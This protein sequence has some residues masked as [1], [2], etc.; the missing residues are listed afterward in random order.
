ML[1]GFRF[2]F[3]AIILSMSILVF[4]LGAAAL[5]RAAHEQFASTPAWRAGPETN[6]AQQT[7]VPRDAARDATR[8]VLA[9]LRVEPE[10]RSSDRIPAVNI[11]VSAEPAAMASPPAEPEQI[12]ASELLQPETT[13]PAVARPDPAAESPQQTE[14]AAAPTDAVTDTAEAAPPAAETKVAS[15]EQS[16]S[17]QILS[18]Q[19][20]SPQVLSP[21]NDVAPVISESAASEPVSAPAA[22]ATDPASTRIATLGGPA[23]AIAT[24]PVKVAVSAKPDQDA[25]RKRQQ[26]RRAAHRRRLAAR[27]RLAARLAAQQP[28]DP[29]G[30]QLAQPPAAARKH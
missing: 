24:S 14:A 15:T 2:L 4:G 13:T 29:F 30:Q 22:A 11:A 18:P 25:I 19:V 9:M 1:P 16:L 27:A 26:A 12:A 20:L 17:L 3:V 10:P 6:F 8:P 5:L 7:D 28:A 23:V 21:A